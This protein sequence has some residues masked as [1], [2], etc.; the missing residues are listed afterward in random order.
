[1]SKTHHDL[2]GTAIGPGDF[3]VYAAL[4]SRSPVL[5]Y[6]VV[7][8]LAERDGYGGTAA[9]IRVISVDRTYRDDW[10]LQRGGK[11]TTLGFLDRLL[12]IPSSTVPEAAMRLL[13]TAYRARTK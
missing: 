7:T 9:T 2:A 5:K 12:V 10:E 8:R 1:M 11:D 6:G 13:D 3:I 4:W